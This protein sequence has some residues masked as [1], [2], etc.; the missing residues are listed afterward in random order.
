[1]AGVLIA[2]AGTGS[3]T[4]LGENKIFFCIN[5]QPMIRKTAEIFLKHPMVQG[6]TVVCAPKEE[7][8]IRSILGE[9]VE[10]VSGGE[11]RGE[12]VFNG[13]KAIRKKYDAV[14][15]HDAARPYVTPE[16]ITRVLEAVVSGQGA[17]AGVP[18]TDTVKRCDAHRMVADTP[19]RE[20]LW[21]AQTPQAFMLEE[22]F[23]AY[24]AAGEKNYTD[25]AAV[26]E[27]WGGKVQMVPGSYGNKKITTAEDVKM[28]RELFLS[29]IGFDVHRLIEGRPLIL[30]GEVIPYRMGLD[31]HSDAD[32]LVHSV[33]D[34][35]LGAAGLGDIGR[36]FPDTEERWRGVSSMEL[37]DRVMQLLRE[38][39]FGVV[40]ISAVISAQRPKLCEYLKKMAQN[41]AYAAGVPESRVN[42]AATTTEHLG[43]EGR[44]EGISARS[45]VMLIKEDEE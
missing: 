34:A 14:L 27:A 2:A 13:L 40:N 41:I 7:E 42:I 21:L 11:T 38:N 22:I 28:K 25:D 44:G 36:Y 1:M 23:S 20:Q 18:V 17:A 26:F 24:L 12:S 32:V 30:G 35:L 4:G 5:G 16:I 9:S 31:G 37:L 8:R 6:V 10:Y 15:I 45:V 43:F 3:R 39:G 19:P 29:G 33:M